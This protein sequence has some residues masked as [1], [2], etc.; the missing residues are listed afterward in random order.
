ML[1]IG[2]DGFQIGVITPN[3]G[4]TFFGVE[5]AHP[6]DGEAATL[7]AGG[8]AGEGGRTSTIGSMLMLVA[9]LPA[10]RE[11]GDDG[12]ASGDVCTGGDN[13]VGGSGVP[14]P[15][16]ECSGGTTPCAPW[17]DSGE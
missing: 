3:P 14:G 13:G 9:P 15:A 11:P 2:E 16:M 10:D 5:G 8:N 7:D 17:S 1:G 12:V 6:G 4:S